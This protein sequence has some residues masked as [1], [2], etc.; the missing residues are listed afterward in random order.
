MI[1]ERSDGLNDITSMKKSIMKKIVAF[2]IVFV[3]LASL[4]IA[5]FYHRSKLGLI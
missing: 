3:Q 5:S 2:N 1:N 4:H